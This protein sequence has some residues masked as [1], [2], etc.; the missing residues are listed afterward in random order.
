M[1]KNFKG[2]NFKC[3]TSCYGQEDKS[4]SCTHLRAWAYGKVGGEG[5]GC[6]CPPKFE[7]LDVLKIREEMKE[8]IRGNF[9]M[10]KNSF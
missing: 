6:T 2:K 4:Q 3:T 8:E 9:K 10:V 7:K 1:R 5:W